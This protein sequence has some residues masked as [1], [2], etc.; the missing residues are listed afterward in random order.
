MKVMVEMMVMMMGFDGV[1]PV[2]TLKVVVV[3]CG[4]MRGGDGALEEEMCCVA[5]LGKEGRKK[6][7]ME[8]GTRR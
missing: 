5:G 3:G 4:A 6:I 7:N 8:K 1:G 2:E